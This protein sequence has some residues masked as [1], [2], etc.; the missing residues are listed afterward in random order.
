MPSHRVHISGICKARDKDNKEVQHSSNN[1][2][3]RALGTPW[4]EALTPNPS[5]NHTVRCGGQTPSS[6]ESDAQPACF[7]AGRNYKERQH[8]HLLMD[9]PIPP[10]AIW[11]QRGN[12]WGYRGRVE[13]QCKGSERQVPA[14]GQLPGQS[15]MKVLIAF[16]HWL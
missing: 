10:P 4:N 16:L 9:S 11:S 7:S 2:S 5:L 8:Q 3:H 12:N 15:E 6:V 13:H 14:A 1:G